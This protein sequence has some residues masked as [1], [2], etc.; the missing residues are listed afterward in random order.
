MLTTQQSSHLPPAKQPFRVR[1]R[2][3]ETWSTVNAAQR[4]RSSTWASDTTL[5]ERPRVPAGGQGSDEN[6]AAE[7]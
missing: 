3:P 4:T 7:R 6:A 2:R 1:L 5:A